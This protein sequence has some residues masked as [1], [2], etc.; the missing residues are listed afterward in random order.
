M[1]KTILTYLPHINVFNLLAPEVKTLSFNKWLRS[2]I[3]TN[4]SIQMLFVN[5]KYTSSAACYQFTIILLLISTQQAFRNKWIKFRDVSVPFI[6]IYMY[7]FI[8]AQFFTEIKATIN[9]DGA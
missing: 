3:S 6:C 8:Q 2:N 4:K 7:I 1:S 5:E 9:M